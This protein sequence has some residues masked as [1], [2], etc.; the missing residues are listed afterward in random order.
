MTEATPL[1]PILD[2]ATVAQLYVL[3]RQVKDEDIVAELLTVFAKDAVRYHVRMRDA[4][5]ALDVENAHAAAHAFKGACLAVGAVRIASL[6]QAAEQHTCAQITA[7]IPD[8]AREL[9][10][11]LQTWADVR[12]Q[13]KS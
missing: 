6:C 11:A 13:T 7:V 12:A 10:L 8:I 3:Q 9:D 5:A 1:L 4:A 2:Q